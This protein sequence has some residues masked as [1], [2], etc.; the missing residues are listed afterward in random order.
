[1]EAAEPDILTEVSNNINT[2]TSRLNIQESSEANNT[3][4]LRKHPANTTYE[5]AADLV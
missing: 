5:Y 2:A 1:V 4:T 3:E